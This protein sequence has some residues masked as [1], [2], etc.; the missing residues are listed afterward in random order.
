MVLLKPCEQIITLRNLEIRSVKADNQLEIK[1]RTSRKPKNCIFATLNEIPQLLT[2]CSQRRRKIASR[3]WTY[4]CIG[5]G[6]I[7]IWVGRSSVGKHHDGRVCWRKPRANPS[8]EGDKPTKV[9]ERDNWERVSHF[10]MLS[11]ICSSQNG[12]TFSG[13][14]FSPS[15]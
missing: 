11:T 15:R 14:L 7:R 9:G 3:R 1:C 12:P 10:E 6:M 5:F 4:W 13:F 8:S 2:F